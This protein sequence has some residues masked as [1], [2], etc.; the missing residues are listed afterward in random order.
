MN[1]I[2]LSLGIWSL[3]IAAISAG[4]LIGKHDK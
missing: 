4:Y 2:F 3:G 1:F